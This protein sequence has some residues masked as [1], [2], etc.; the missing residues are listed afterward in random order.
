MKK[1]I[2]GICCC[3]V[4][5]ACSITRFHSGSFNYGDGVEIKPVSTQDTKTLDRGNNVVGQTYV[6][7][8]GTRFRGFTFEVTNTSNQARVVDFSE[9]YLID[10]DGNK[11]QADEAGQTMKIELS[12]KMKH[13][14][15]A[16]K[17][18]TFLV[19]FMP[20]FPMDEKYPKML[21][22]DQIIQLK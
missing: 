4:L 22:G 11:Y 20:A 17:K 13:T 6:A 5:A 19:D 1:I 16:G 10:S 7:P 14:I 9:F 8:K 3:L 12:N 18:R 15:K 21:V 2:A